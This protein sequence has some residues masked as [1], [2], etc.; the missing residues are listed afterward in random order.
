[1]V[2]LTAKHWRL[3]LLRHMFICHIWAQHEV[4]ESHVNVCY[5]GS[6]FTYVFEW[7][8][9]FHQMSKRMLND[10]GGP[11]VHF[12]LAVIRPAND[13]FNALRHEHAKTAMRSKRRFTLKEYIVLPWMT[14]YLFNR[15][16]GL[17]SVEDHLQE[18]WEKHK[19][20]TGSYWHLCHFGTPLKSLM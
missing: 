18:G 11:Q 14:W 7:P 10:T 15:A 2:Q 20:T 9:L 19:Q 16:T 12:T 8:P 6:W 5:V 17:I 4:Q 13:T 1:M 3:M